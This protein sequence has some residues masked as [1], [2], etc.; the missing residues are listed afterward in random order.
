MVERLGSGDGERKTLLTRQIAFEPLP[1]SVLFGLGSSWGMSVPIFVDSVLIVSTGGNCHAREAHR[2]HSRLPRSI[3][4]L[5]LL[6]LFCAWRACDDWR[7]GRNA[8][9]TRRLI[10]QLIRNTRNATKHPS[11]PL[12]SASEC[13]QRRL[14][15]RR[16][17]QIIVTTMPP[18]EPELDAAKKTGDGFEVIA[19]KLYSCPN[20]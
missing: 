19:W 18:I 4:A 5:Q 12:A 10:G 15:I 2:A 1:A 6:H 16:P 8:I 17:M 7:P 3:G 13:T 11:F 14:H 9:H 20:V